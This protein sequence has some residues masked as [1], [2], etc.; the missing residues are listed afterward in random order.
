MITCQKSITINV[1]SDMPTF[2][3]LSMPASATPTIQAT[4]DAG[5]NSK[6]KL[7]KNNAG[8][9][10][11]VGTAAGMSITVHTGEDYF[12]ASSQADATNFWVTGGNLTDRVIRFGQ[13]SAGL[14]VIQMFGQTS[15][16]GTYG[17][18]APTYDYANSVGGANEFQLPLTITLG[19]SLTEQAAHMLV[20]AVTFTDVVH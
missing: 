3:T 16:P 8:A 13:N 9:A 1:L 7:Y 6:W 17:G 2:L 11:L 20:F 10:L 14:N 19:A 5:F 18:F 4:F 15:A 12:V